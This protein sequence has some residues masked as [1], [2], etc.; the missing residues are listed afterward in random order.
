[1]RPPKGVVQG[2]RRL[3]LDEFGA[4]FQRA[5]LR[6]DRRFIKLECW[7]TYQEPATESLPEFLRGDRRRVLE[8]LRTEA[9]ADGVLYADVARRGVEYARVRL[10]RVPLS[11]YL[12]WELWSYRVRQCLGER[13]LLVSVGP[14][15]PLPNERD[16]DFLL[17]DRSVALVHDYGEDGLQVGGWLVDDPPVLRQLERRAL[18]REREAEPLADFLRRVELPPLPGAEAVEGEPDDGLGK[19]GGRAAVPVAGLLG[20]VPLDQ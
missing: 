12:E 14:G 19:V 13:I 20:T 9:A 6:L 4:E 10:A 15:L 3:S 17:F 8:L 18:E 2:G 11:R 16:F 7:Q 5:W 1:M